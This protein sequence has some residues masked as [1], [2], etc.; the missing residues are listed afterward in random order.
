MKKRSV[1]RFYS[2]LVVLILWQLILGFSYVLPVKAASDDDIN[3]ALTKAC[4]YVNSNIAAFGEGDGDWAALGLRKAGNLEIALLSPQNPQKPSDYARLII[5]GLARGEDVAGYVGTLQSM[6]KAGGYFSSTDNEDTLNQTIWAVIALNLAKKNGISVSFNETGAVNYICS[7]QK[8]EGDP[9]AG[10]FDESGWGV[11]IDSTAH[12]LVALAPYKNDGNVNETINRALEFLKNKQND[13]AGFGFYIWNGEEV[14]SESPDSIAA[15]IEALVALGI[16]P[17]GDEWKKDNKT[18]VDALLKYQLENGAFYAPW[19]PGEANT[20]STRSALL[21]LADLKKV[22]G[23]Y[24]S[25]YNNSL[26]PLERLYISITVPSSPNAG[27]DWSFSM[28][29]NNPEGQ[30]KETLTVAGLYRV[31]K[32]KPEKMV[33]Y[34]SL[35]KNVA[36]GQSESISGGMSIIENGTYEARIMVWDNWQNRTP[37]A[38]PVV[39]KVNS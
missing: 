16:D 29:I 3:E 27:T 19:K 32:D 9:Y 28:R 26:P 5:G 30:D 33:Y 39:F 4:L 6:Q 14:Q 31:E 13:K 10:G 37:L 1:C 25:K 11:D 36:A 17:Q 20:M 22:N 34:T 18:M 38:K 2:I 24:V 7:K 35:A 23:G 12:A 21:A 15:V 8:P